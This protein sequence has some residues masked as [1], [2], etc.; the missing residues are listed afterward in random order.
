MYPK[1]FWNK[2]K[3]KIKYGCA[4]FFGTVIVLFVMAWILSRQAAAIFNMVA[5]KQHFFEGTITVEALSAT[6]LGH[7]HFENLVWKSEGGENQVVIPDGHFHVKPL[8]FIFKRVSTSTIDNLEL[9]GADIALTFDDRMHIKGIRA[10]ERVQKP[11]K[12]D[13]GKKKKKFD[14]KLKN[15]NVIVTLNHCRLTAYYKNRVHTF[16]DVNA[17]LHYDSNDKLTIDFS[18]GELG[19]TLE[20]GGVD[21]QGTIDLKPKIST[22][23]LQLGIKE[24]N[25]SSLGTGLDIHETVTA[26]AAVTGQ[27]PEPVIVGKLYMKSLTLP[28]LAFTNLRGNFKYKDGY[29]G[30]QNVTA[31]VFGGTCDAHGGF[32]IDTKAYDVYVKGHNLKS[33]V[34]ANAPYFKTLVELDLTMKCDGNPKSTLTYGSFTSGKGIYALIKFDSISGAF[35]NQYKRLA[36]DDVQIKSQGGDIVAPQFELIDGKLHLGNLYFVSPNGTR[37]LIRF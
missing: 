27:L 33:E 16:K 14:I 5:A 8:D 37:S 6:P 25:P 2:H 23:D 28:G 7:V 17:T 22:Y 1:R 29:I 36:F 3:R 15:L 32:N 12:K 34:A 31:D 26:G 13:N 4:I 30:A 24:L 20:G 21:I 18:T 35:S 19:G 9:N 10:I 11:K